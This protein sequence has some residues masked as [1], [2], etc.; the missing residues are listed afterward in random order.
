MKIP[1]TL[2][3]G[4]GKEVKISSDILDET[5]QL[6]KEEIPSCEVIEFSKSGHMIPDEEP[7]KYIEK[8]I[9]FINKIECNN[10]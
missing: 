10:V 7:E 8:I 4:R 1:V 2:F 6:Y 9:S 5:L 3:V